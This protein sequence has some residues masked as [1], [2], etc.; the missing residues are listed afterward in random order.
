[1][2]CTQCMVLVVTANCDVFA[3]MS[4]LWLQQ[5][6]DCMDCEPGWLWSFRVTKAQEGVCQEAYLYYCRDLQT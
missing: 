2:Q 4:G 3:R 5:W 1:M 6:Q